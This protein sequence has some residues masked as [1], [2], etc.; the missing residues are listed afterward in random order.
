M[1][2]IDQ[3]TNSNAKGIEGGNDLQPLLDTPSSSGKKQQNSKAKPRGRPWPKGVSGNPAG[4]PRGVKNIFSQ[5]VLAAANA[6]PATERD[7]NSL[8]PNYPALERGIY[9]FQRGR[10]FFIDTKKAVPGPVPIPPELFDRR[11]QRWGYELIFKGRQ[12]LFSF[13]GWLYDRETLKIII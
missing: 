3:H 6:N 8:D 2:S 10:K 13:D 7:S 9:Y 1:N 4:R 12:C 11:R 5:M